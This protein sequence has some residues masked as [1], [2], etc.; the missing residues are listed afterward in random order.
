MLRIG[1]SIVTFSPRSSAG[2]RQFDQA[3]VERLVQPMILALAVEA[4]DF[5]TDLRLMEDAAEIEA[6]RLPVL[7]ALLRVEQVRATDQIVE[8]PYPELCHE[9]AHLLGDDRRN[10]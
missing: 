1:I 9:L 7:D 5:G 8:A 10:S 4:R 6:T 3:M 2:L